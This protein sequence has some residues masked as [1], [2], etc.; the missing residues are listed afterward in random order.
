MRTETK[1][2][3]PCA[4][5]RERTVSGTTTAQSANTLAAVGAA[6][7]AMDASLPYIDKCGDRKG[8]KRNWIG[9][10]AGQALSINE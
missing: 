1:S 8:Q 2:T 7:I 3:L 5:A 10:P 6:Q 4:A 9:N